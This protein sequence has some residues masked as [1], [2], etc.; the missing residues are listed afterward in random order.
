MS[1]AVPTDRGPRCEC[2]APVEWSSRDN[3]YLSVRTGRTHAC[4]IPERLA[5]PPSGPLL[6]QIQEALSKCPCGEDVLAL[7]I[8]GR[9]FVNFN[10]T[11]HEHEQPRSLQA[12]RAQ[13]PTPLRRVDP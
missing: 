3:V 10:V 2:G 4:P 5:R 12:A 7:E 1:T 8:P 13:A 11:R 9:G 6:A